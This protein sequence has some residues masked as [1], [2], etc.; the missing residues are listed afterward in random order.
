M[1]ALQQLVKQHPD[2]ESAQQLAAKLEEMEPIDGPVDGMLSVGLNKPL[3]LLDSHTHRIMEMQL[4]LPEQSDIKQKKVS[5]LT[6][7]GIALIGEHKGERIMWPIGGGYR[8]VTIMEIG[9]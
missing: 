3:V 1:H 6:P 8:E 4:V 9:E 5:V 2:N 7:I